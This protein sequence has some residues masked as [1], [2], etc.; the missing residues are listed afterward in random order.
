[1]LASLSNSVFSEVG[2]P[3]VVEI[4]QL[5]WVL[6]T[7]T[8][9]GVLIMSLISGFVAKLYSG[10]RLLSGVQLPYGIQLHSGILIPLPPQ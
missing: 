5:G 2:N 4:H 9:A 10:A 3:L 1:V 6:S 7:S 8:W